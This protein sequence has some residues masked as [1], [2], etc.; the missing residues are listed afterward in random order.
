MWL[1]PYK[2]ADTR[3]LSGGCGGGGEIY[4]GRMRSGLL[5]N[6]LKWLLNSS[7]IKTKQMIYHIC[8]KIKTEI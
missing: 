1:R 2:R 5:G 4:T 3:G 8:M 6:Y 7:Y